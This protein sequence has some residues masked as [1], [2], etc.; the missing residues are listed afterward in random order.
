MEEVDTVIKYPETFKQMKPAGYDGEFSWDFLAPIFKGSKIQLTDIDAVVER[1][2]N[3]LFF[4]TKNV[5]VP[6]PS[7]QRI[8]L[9]RLVQLGKGKITIFVL[10]GKTADTITGMERWIWNTY[11]KTVTKEG[12]EC[13][14]DY[15]LKMVDGWFKIACGRL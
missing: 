10:Y 6:I 7:G 5:G 14:S 4:E 1:R 12:G 2:D 15:V 9:E 13:D 8:L 11:T 3:F